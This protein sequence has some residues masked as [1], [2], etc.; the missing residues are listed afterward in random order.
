MASRQHLE[1][2]LP[3]ARREVSA[4]VMTR[5]MNSLRNFKDVTLLEAFFIKKNP[6]WR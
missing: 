2:H 3:S 6:R 5:Y 1:T 4:K